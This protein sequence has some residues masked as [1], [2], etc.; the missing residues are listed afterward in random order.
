MGRKAMIGEVNQVVLK[1]NIYLCNVADDELPPPVVSPKD[2]QRC[3]VA[4]SECQ[5]EFEGGWMVRRYIYN[6]P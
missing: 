1:Y 5:E 2:S 4:M 6:L 3:T